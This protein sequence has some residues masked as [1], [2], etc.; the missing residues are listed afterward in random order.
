VEAV[1]VVITVIYWSMLQLVLVPIFFKNRANILQTNDANTE[2]DDFINLQNKS[3][4]ETIPLNTRVL[5]FCQRKRLLF[6]DTWSLT[7]ETQENHIY[8]MQKVKKA[9]SASYR[10]RR[11]FSVPK[12]N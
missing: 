5:T 12:R 10:V 3:I 1:E 4:C 11:S 2:S 8:S 6:V 9:G 7:L